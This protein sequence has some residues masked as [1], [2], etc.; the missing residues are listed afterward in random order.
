[1]G[2]G[3]AERRTARTRGG[4]PSNKKWKRAISLPSRPEGATLVPAHDAMKVGAVVIVENVTLL[5][6]D[7]TSIDGTRHKK[8]DREG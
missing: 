5:R 4:R 3:D 8:K 1:M 2:Q 7:G 6:T